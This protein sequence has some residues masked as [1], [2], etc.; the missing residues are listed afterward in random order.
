M[1]PSNQRLRDRRR[2]TSAHQA[3]QV[4]HANSRALSTDLCWPSGSGLEPQPGSVGQPG[5]PL[6]A[7]DRGN[8]HSRPDSRWAGAAVMPSTLPTRLLGNT[9][10]R[11]TTN[12]LGLLSSSRT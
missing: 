2:Y 9:P 10:Q 3:P 7:K 1:L 12:H 11:G 5:H 6:G 4:C 8:A